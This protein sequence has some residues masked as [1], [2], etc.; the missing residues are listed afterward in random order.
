MSAYQHLPRRAGRLRVGPLKELQPVC[1]ISIC[2]L[3][4]GTSASVH[5]EDEGLR[6]SMTDAV[7][8]LQGKLR[9]A[10]VC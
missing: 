6:T 10:A 3:E 9:L 1:N 8:V 4:T 2:F 5:P 7:D